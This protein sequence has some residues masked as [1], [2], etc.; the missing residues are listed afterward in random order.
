MTSRQLEKGE[1]RERGGDTILVYFR[2]VCTHTVSK[3]A[4]K[5]GQRFRGGEGYDR[6][7]V[8]SSLS[9]KRG[10]K[11]A[12]CSLRVTGGGGGHPSQ[13]PGGQSSKI[14][15][16]AA[17]K[18]VRIKRCGG[19]HDTSTTTRWVWSTRGHK[20]PLKGLRVQRRE[21][22]TTPVYFQVFP[23][24]KVVAR[25]LHVARGPLGD[26]HYPCLIASS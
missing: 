25:Q 11:A 23:P 12:P 8:S 9:S 26:G 2:V 20:P 7:L 5:K 14:V 17:L 10:C 13:T 22:W 1:L 6:S 24:R 18:G 19:R 15:L 21:G 4:S 3:N 16:K